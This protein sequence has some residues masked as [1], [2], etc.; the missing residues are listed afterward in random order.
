MILE[1]Q[2]TLALAKLAYRAG[3]WMSEI[4][5]DGGRMA[6]SLEAK[7]IRSTLR[8][9]RQ[10][11]KDPAL[12]EILDVVL[13]ADGRW[14]QWGG[15]IADF[16]EELRS[17]VLDMPDSFKECLFDVALRV[18]VTFRERSGFSSFLETAIRTLRGIVSP[19]RGGVTTAE[20]VSISPAEKVAL[21]QLADILYLPHRHID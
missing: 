11:R 19:L 21:N 9:M 2:K 6:S 14:D 15:A 13:Q 7:V 12:L 3:L 1:E 5:S 18:A 20:Y 16:P 10:S 17:S 4:D 8:A